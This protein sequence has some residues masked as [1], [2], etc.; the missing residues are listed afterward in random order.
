MDPDVKSSSIFVTFSAPQFFL[1][2][3]PNPNLP[4]TLWR[5]A[6]NAAVPCTLH[7]TSDGPALADRLWIETAGGLNDNL[8][9]AQLQKYL[10]RRRMSFSLQICD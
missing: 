1:R 3:K 6:P 8:V 7:S 9:G 2:D 4:R 5:P 10:W